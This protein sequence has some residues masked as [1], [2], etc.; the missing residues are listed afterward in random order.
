MM[1]E[2]VTV[3]QVDKKPKYITP[4][5]LRGKRN[6][7]NI[8][9]KK[10]L[11]S[12]DTIAPNPHYS[13]APE[14]KL[15]LLDRVIEVEKS[16]DFVQYGTDPT[17]KDATKRVVDIKIKNLMYWAQTV[18]IEYDFPD[19]SNLYGNAREKVNY[20]RCECTEYDHTMCDLYGKNGKHITHPIIKN[21]ILIEIGKCYPYLADEVSRQSI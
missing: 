18:E 2:E 10:L 16:D 12:P 19:S 6:W 1:Q 8:M 4:T 17:R 13:C 3:Q 20:L 15:Y 7:T 14:M 5:G 11:G 9:I 21:R